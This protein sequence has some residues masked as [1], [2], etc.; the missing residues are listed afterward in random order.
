MSF[1]LIVW[2]D[3]QWIPTGNRFKT[4]EAAEESG[5]RL[6]TLQSAGLAD[7]EVRESAEEPNQGS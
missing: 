4:R 1:E 3:E 2:L 5:K 6:Y 7:V